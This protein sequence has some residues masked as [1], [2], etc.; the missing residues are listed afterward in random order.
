[1]SDAHCSALRIR[2]GVPDT[3]PYRLHAV[4]QVTAHTVAQVTAHAVALSLE[5]GY[6]GAVAPVSVHTVALA[7]VHVAVVVVV[8]AVA[9]VAVLVQEN[10]V[11]GRVS[12]HQPVVCAKG[13]RSL[14][15]SD[16]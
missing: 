15:W 5:V 9:L 2:R 13:T 10:A 6:T 14:P 1:M 7:L 8:Q 3:D 11:M 4:V 16:S 12:G